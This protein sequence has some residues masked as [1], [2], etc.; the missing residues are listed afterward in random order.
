MKKILFIAYDGLTES[1]GQ[2]QILP[3]MEG[4]A[5]A[6]YQ[7][8]ILSCEKS[9]HLVQIE[10]KIRSRVK[11]ANITWEFITFTSRPPII[12]KLYDLSR[13][14]KKAHSLYQREKFDVI[15]CRS[16]VAA[17]VGLMLKKKYGVKFI[18][19]MR[20][21]WA[22]ERKDSG[23]WNTK[24]LF[25]RCLYNK[26]K[27]KEREFLLSA[28]AIIVLTHAAEKEIRRWHYCENIKLNIQVIPCCCDLNLFSVVTPE[29][30][31]LSRKALNISPSELVIS[32]LGSLG[33][34][35][36]LDEMLKFFALVK[37]KYQLSKFL[38]VTHSDK[39]MV[40]NKLDLYGLKENDVVVVNATREEVPLFI[41]ASDVGLSFIT[42]TYS[43]IAS[44]P[45]KVG[46]ILSMGIPIVGNTGIG[47][48]D[49]L[50]NRGIGHVLKDFSLSQMQDAVNDIPHL[51]Q[52]N[53]EF[54]RQQVIY[55]YDL[56][57]A[58]DKY[59]AVYAQLT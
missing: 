24:N 40:Y 29:Q 23:A 1:I 34:Y 51:L 37:Q 3:Y 36:L 46:E 9:Q 21:F 55:D 35:Y 59:L 13:L 50:I 18:F 41:K 48:V 49:E 53:P 16:Y 14:R 2:S 25:Y 4:L 39:T 5:A 27:C 15:H 30:K 7:V 54:I 20:G 45:I 6:N 31:E 17:S 43:K 57:I 52:L 26:Y 8:T 11:Q 47:D 58:I 28:D 10:D 56:K 19:D 12:S 42:P 33:T 32:Y 44:S 22:D 38:V